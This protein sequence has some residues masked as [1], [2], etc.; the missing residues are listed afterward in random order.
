V[1]NYFIAAEARARPLELSDVSD[2]ASSYNAQWQHISD[3]FH[4]AAAAR[5]NASNRGRLACVKSA[6]LVT[7]IT[8]VYSGHWE[9]DP[10][11]PRHPDGSPLYPLGSVN[12]YW[13]CVK[14]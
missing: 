10:G 9:Y 1:E 2:V 5:D 13:H 4:A 3:Q 14:D 12:V 11:G 7:C 6:N 8:P